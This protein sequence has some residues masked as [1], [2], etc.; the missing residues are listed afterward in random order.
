MAN[1]VMS[2]VDPLGNTIILLEGLCFENE[3]P[4]PGVYDTVVNVI[5]KPA[6]M[7]S[8]ETDHS[9]LHYYYRSIEWHNTMLISVLYKNGKWY[10]EK[11]IRNPSN[12]V[13]SI[14]L[15]SGKQIL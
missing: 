4:D 3:K 11:C 1:E 2:I 15:K 14:L 12:E 13:L 10:S 5:Q 7:I 9:T 8:V 6:M